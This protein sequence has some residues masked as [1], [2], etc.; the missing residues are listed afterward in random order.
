MPRYKMIVNPTSGRGQGEQSYPII[1]AELRKLGLEYDMCRTE[2]PGHAIQ[3]AQ[4]AVR[5]LDQDSGAV[6]GLRVAAAGA[7]VL[8]VHEHLDALV[9]QRMG[10][11]APDVGNEADPAGI[12]LVGGIVEPLGGPHFAVLR[13]RGPPCASCVH[14]SCVDRS[15]RLT[16]ANRQCSRGNPEAC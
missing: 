10:F 2:S 7:S 14:S 13:D 4:E 1:D 9:D 12:V 6:P 8:E 16:P 3:L 15:T 5:E 11:L